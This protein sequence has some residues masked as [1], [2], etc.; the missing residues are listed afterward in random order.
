M[1]DQNPFCECGN[2]PYHHRLRIGWEEYGV[3]A[4]KF[5]GQVF[6]QNPECLVVGYE[7]AES[8]ESYVAV[9]KTKQKQE[10]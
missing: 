6:I 2:D 8:G 9:R 5:R 3:L 7:V 1:S 4:K 10:E